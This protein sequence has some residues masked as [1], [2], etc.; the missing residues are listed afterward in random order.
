MAVVPVEVKVTV[1]R[2]QG[3]VVLEEKQMRLPALESVGLP[4]LMYLRR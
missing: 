2:V 3:P 4:I 1:C